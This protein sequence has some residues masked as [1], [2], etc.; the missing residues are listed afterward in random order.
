MTE[1][2]DCPCRTCEFASNWQWRGVVKTDDE[3]GD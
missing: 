2:K 3:A 1:L